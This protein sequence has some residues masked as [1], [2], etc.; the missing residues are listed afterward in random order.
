MT[1]RCKSKIPMDDRENLFELLMTPEEYMNI[2]KEE[3]AVDSTIKDIEYPISGDGLSKIS[4]LL[5]FYMYVDSRC[6]DW[7]SFENCVAYGLNGRVIG[8][9][10][11]I[12][13]V[14][15]NVGYQAK[16][17]R[18]QLDI[19]IKQ[20]TCDND[21]NKVN[22]SLYKDTPQKLGDILISKISSSQT[23]SFY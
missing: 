19:K 20:I 17:A 9:N 16:F 13:V 1:K 11:F 14:S 22:Y 7:D 4:K 18:K 12:D 15:G 5:K 2:K 21:G 10:S 8:D 6:I 3:V 23:I